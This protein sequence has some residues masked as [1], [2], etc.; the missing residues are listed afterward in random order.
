[1]VARASR[2]T[3]SSVDFFV[4]EHHE[5][6]T[7]LATISDVAEH[8]GRFSSTDLASILSSLLL[9][10]EVVVRAAYGLGGGMALSRP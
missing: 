7:E 10:L 1:M 3:Q 6:T 5:I 2:P 4:Q 8:V 9:W